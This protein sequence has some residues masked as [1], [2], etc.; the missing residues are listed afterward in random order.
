[1]KKN[2]LWLFVF[3]S[4]YFLGEAQKSITFNKKT[5][6][7][8]EII[9]AEHFYANNNGKEE[10]YVAV[11]DLNILTQTIVEYDEKN[12]IKA[13][14]TNTIN[15]NMLDL[16]KTYVQEIS[17]SLYK[18][19]TIYSVRIQPKAGYKV[20]QKYMFPGD[21]DWQRTTEEVGQLYANLEVIANLLVKKIQAV[22]QL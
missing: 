15:L 5:I 2:I 22:K 6:E 1:M 9:W 7:V 19:P 14:Y 10:I 11:D 21:T 17:R 3:L 8:P 16:S 20:I 18:T 13:V 4:S 12:A